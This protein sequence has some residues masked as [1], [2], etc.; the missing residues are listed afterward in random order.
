MSFLGKA[1]GSKG[2]KRTPTGSDSKSSGAASGWDRPTSQPIRYTSHS[3]SVTMP[4]SLPAPE[5]VAST[6]VVSAVTKPI[7][8][9]MLG[10]TVSSSLP[11]Q[12]PPIS[13]ARNDNA[14]SFVGVSV[15][16]P[17]QTRTDF[18][19]GPPVSQSSGGAVAAVATEQSVALPVEF[20]TAP[21]L[22][23]ASVNLD[24]ISFDEL[25]Q[26]FHYLRSQ[27]TSVQKEYD[28]LLIRG[29][30]YMDETV[31][32]RN[33]VACQKQEL[34]EKGRHLSEQ[35]RLVCQYT[36]TMQACSAEC[37][38]SQERV[39][40]LDLKLQQQDVLLSKVRS[41]LGSVVAERDQLKLLVALVRPSPLPHGSFEHSHDLLDVEQGQ[42]SDN[43]TAG[44]YGDA[45]FRFGSWS[46]CYSS[47]DPYSSGDARW[48]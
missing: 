14:V 12:S 27:F 7:S 18:V 29:Q 40:E 28:V 32:L 3:S 34:A 21:K 31:E 37:N 43:H 5:L 42:I 41:D 33:Q 17:S 22:P 47:N 11:V 15:D 20:A 35:E 13:T 48:R 23:Y 10:N 36:L 2:L 46:V 25:R 6:V 30:T 24:T 9:S 4:V 1:F 26:N 44:V 45:A 38:A 19:S 8:S 39:K 16:S